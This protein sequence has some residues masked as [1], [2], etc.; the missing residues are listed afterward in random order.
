MFLCILTAPQL[1]QR[2]A[3]SDYVIDQP[4]KLTGEF[5]G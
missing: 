1:C 3:V 4:V 5:S 2:S